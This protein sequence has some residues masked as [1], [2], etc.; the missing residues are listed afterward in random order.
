MA[1]SP[2]RR[3]IGTPARGGKKHEA[4]RQEAKFSVLHGRGPRWSW[5]RATEWARAGEADH[6]LAWTACACALL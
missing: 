3:A 5:P 6:L 2:S 1:E 4:K